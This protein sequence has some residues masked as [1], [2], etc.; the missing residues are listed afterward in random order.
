MVRAPAVAGKFYDATARGVTREIEASY[1]H[2]VG[3]GALPPR[4]AKWPSGKPWG[5]VVPHAGYVFS[6]PVAAHAFFDIAKRGVPDT[7]I[8]LGPSHHMISH[9]LAVSGEGWRT[10][11]GVAACDEGLVR[12]LVGGPIARCDE[13]FQA[14][15]SLE[16]EVPFLQ[17]IGPAVKIAPLIMLDQSLKA[18]K[19]VGA[20]VAEAITAEPGKSIG[21]LA[22][23]DFTHYESPA[24]AAA[25][26]AHALAAIA[27]G[28]AA[29]LDEAVRGHDISMCGPGPTM[30]LLEAVKPKSTQLL[31]YANSADAEFMKGMAEVVAY[32]A[33]RVA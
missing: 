33:I 28:S 17:H 24:T 20:R 1:K 8:I 2:K 6:G 9:D 15:H 18:A 21:V 4:A 26:D 23:S 10:P 16:V 14:E 30:A 11:L 12:R 27:R 29:E 5:Y 32:A 22:S 31:K 25:Q 19:T 7:V 13:D 3:P